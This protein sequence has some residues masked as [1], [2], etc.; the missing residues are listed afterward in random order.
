MEKL[1]ED[2]FELVYEV[3]HGKVKKSLT[4]M[5]QSVKTIFAAAKDSLAIGWKYVTNYEFVYDYEKG[6]MEAKAYIETVRV[7]AVES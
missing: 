6:V 3:F 4:R 2:T 7:I 5:Y 1:F